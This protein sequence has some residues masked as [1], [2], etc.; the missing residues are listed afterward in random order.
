MLWS[1]AIVL[2]VFF[3][4]MGLVL[5]QAFQLSTEQ[6]VEEKLRIQ[7]YGLLSVTEVTTGEL[8]L[9]E[10]L[11]EPR[12]NNPSSGLYALIRNKD[13]DELWRSP[14]TV[15]LDFSPQQSASQTKALR[16]GEDRFERLSDHNV[17]YLAYKILWL[18]AGDEAQEFVFVVMESVD[19]YQNQLNRYRNNLWGWLVLVGVVLVATQAVLM[20]WGLKPLAGL[21]TDLAAIES[22]KQQSLGGD[23]PNE[24]TGVTR[25]LNVL[26]SSE[27]TQRE[28]Y[29]T[30][31]ADLAHSIKTPLAIL[32]GSASQLESG[33]AVPEVVQTIDEQ[34]QRM[35]EIVSYQLERAKSDASSLIKST[36]DVVPVAERLIS[37]MAK[38]YP[39]RAIE[40]TKSPCTFFGDERDMMELLGNI[41]DNACKY[42]TSRVSIQLGGSNFDGTEVVVEDD[43]PG[44]PADQREGVLQRGAR[45]DSRA[46]GQGIGLAVVTEIVD[47]YHGKIEVSAGEL[48]GA[49]VKI[50]FA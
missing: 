44:I 8:Y 38:V 4:L 40:L 45:L 18:G 30:T 27:R 42:G 22:G 25:N 28:K 14:S 43:G 48:G 11:Q 49:K 19:G 47:R 34:V 26:I 13:G 29:R 2:F 21:A 9:P 7:I 32:K 33:A 31:L 3:G 39:D 1:A 5:D 10:A 41:V 12:F 6:S 50:T 37:A 46:P 15:S 36:I 20:N 16:P 23:Y 17:F 35:D 24:L